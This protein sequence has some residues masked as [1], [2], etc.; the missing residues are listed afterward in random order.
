MAQGEIYLT[1][2]GYDKLMEELEHLK[3]V[4]RRQLSKAIGEARA[5]GDISE[6]AEYDAAKD[7]QGLNEKRIAEMEGKLSR[8]RILDNEAMASDEALIG[9]SVKIKDLES[10]EELIY[11]LVSEEEADYAQG[12]ISVTSPVGQGLLGHKV[13]EVVEI[14]I[15]AGILRYQIL[16]ISRDGS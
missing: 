12:K 13:D 2:E 9:A 1:R 4:K 3:T 6:N 7:A 8:V 11:M 16:H 10:G 15:P 14:K 5:H